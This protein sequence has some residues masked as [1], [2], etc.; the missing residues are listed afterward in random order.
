MRYKLYIGENK[1]ESNIEYCGSYK[2]FHSITTGIIFHKIMEHE[3]LFDVDEVVVSVYDS[4]KD[5]IV[6]SK[7]IDMSLIKTLN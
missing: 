5:E 6:Y 3:E 4:N 2:S 7:V 1:V